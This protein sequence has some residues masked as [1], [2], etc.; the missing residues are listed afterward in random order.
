MQRS[1]GNGRLTFKTRDGRTIL[2]RVYE[3]GCA[4]IRFPE[5]DQAILINTAGGLTGGDDL[6]WSI[7]VPADGAATITT[8]A[9]EKIYRAI[10]PTVARVATRIALGPSARLHWLPQETILFSRSAVERTFD[11]ELAAS[12]SFLAVESV[13]FGRPAMGEVMHHV[14]L[15]DRWRVSRDRRLVHAEDLKIE[16]AAADLL[17]RAAIGA[18]NT[19]FATLLLVSD[20]AERCFGGVL[21]AIGDAGG[22]SAFDGKLLARIATSSAYQLRKAVVSA[23]TA[24]SDG[25]ALPK[26]WAL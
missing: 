15:H 5:P 16:G 20:D 13:V 21:D 3:D 22:A 8:Q 1:Q 7:E 17:T 4:K 24:L 18:N 23:I 19:A 11:V 14:R 25:R 9:S 6:S 26:V 12:S 10:E 2:D